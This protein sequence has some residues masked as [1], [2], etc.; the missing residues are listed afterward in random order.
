M[1]WVG[2]S[3]ES[4]SWMSVV[5]MMETSV[6]LLIGVNGKFDVVVCG[7]GACVFVWWRL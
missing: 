4:S 6:L 5:A 7:V 3:V 1:H 2:R